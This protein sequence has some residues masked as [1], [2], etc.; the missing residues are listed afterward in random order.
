MLSSYETLPLSFYS[1]NL[2][3]LKQ[4]KSLFLQKWNDPEAGNWTILCNLETIEGTS[5][6][7]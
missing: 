3:L 6:L 2:I 5:S 4:D 1:A 7:Y